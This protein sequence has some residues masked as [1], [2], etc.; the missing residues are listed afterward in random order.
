MLE[1][2]RK[3]VDSSKYEENTNSPTLDGPN[4]WTNRSQFLFLELMQASVKWAGNSTATF[5]I[6]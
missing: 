2:G 1:D 4:K 6:P 3:G 5:A